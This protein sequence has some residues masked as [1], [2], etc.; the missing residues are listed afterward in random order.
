MIVDNSNLQVHMRRLHERASLRDPIANSAMHLSKGYLPLFRH[1]TLDGKTEACGEQIV[2]LADDACSR[3]PEALAHPLRMTEL[4][5]LR[6]L[7]ADSA[8]LVPY[9][10]LT[11]GRAGPGEAV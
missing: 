11:R 6:L 7:V 5:Q 4:G 3:E 9:A 1:F 10:S 2:L 8:W